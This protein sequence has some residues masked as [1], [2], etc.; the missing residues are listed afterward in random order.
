[1]RTNDNTSSSV[2]QAHNMPTSAHERHRPR[3]VPAQRGRKGKAREGDGANRRHNRSRYAVGEAT[4][5]LGLG[6]FYARDQG[7][8]KTHLPL[9]GDAAW[10]TPCMPLASASAP[11]PPGLRARFN[12]STASS[13]G[14]SR[15]AR[16]EP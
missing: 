5:T 13:Y 4:L 14:A 10:L 2:S 3:P 8:V 7:A 6:A 16:T 15:P 1:M 12:T 9:R 11:S